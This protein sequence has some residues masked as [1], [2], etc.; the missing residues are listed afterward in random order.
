MRRFRPSPSVRWFGRVP[1]I[2]LLKNHGPYTPSARLSSEHLPPR[3]YPGLVNVDRSSVRAAAAQGVRDA[4]GIEPTVEALLDR[5]S[6]QVGP[7]EVDA[8][9]AVIG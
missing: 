3:G 6:L 8:V 2:L 9:V 1:T 4:L 7:Q 5:L